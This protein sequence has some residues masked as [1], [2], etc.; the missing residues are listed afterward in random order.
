MHI[1]TLLGVSRTTGR[2]ETPFQVY[3]HSQHK[4]S[5]RIVAALLVSVSQLLSPPHHFI[6]TEPFSSSSA[7]SPSMITTPTLLVDKERCQRNMRRMASKAKAANVR[8]RPHCKTHA[9]LAIAQWLQREAGVEC[10]TVSSLTMAKYFGLTFRDI[11]VAFP[12]NILEID[13]INELVGTAD[14]DALRLNLLVENREAIEFLQKHIKASV[15]IF[16]KIDVGYGRTGIPAQ[17]FDRVDQLLKILF[18]NSNDNSRKLYFKGFLAHAGHSYECHS[19]P[20]LL[21]IHDTCKDLLLALKCHFQDK[22]PDTEI[23]LSIGDTPTCSVIEA[24]DLN[25]IQ[26]IR[27]GNFVFYDVEQAEIGSCTYDD[28]AVA[29]ACP[30]VAK[31]PSRRELILYGGGV[32]FS[33][34]RWTDPNEPGRR[35]FGRVVRS[36]DGEPLKWGSVVENMYLRSCSQEH[37]IVVVPP[38]EDFESY[39]IGGILKVLPVHSCMTADVMS[40]KG[41]LTCDGERLSRMKD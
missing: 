16:I 38:E 29:M 21:R 13:T 15:G 23:E 7:P 26:E 17:D 19:K 8:F 41:Y 24:S 18:Q 35:V 11:T 39:Q 25:G 14:D 3:D 4:F 9:S 5:S 20:E 37:G 30:I 32:H 31:H 22:Y 36:V 28:V 10:I 1:T 2:T 40:Q 34:D 6:M 33:K 12:V 27:P